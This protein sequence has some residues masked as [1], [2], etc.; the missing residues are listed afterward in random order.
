MILFIDRLINKIV[1]F[2]ILI[3]F[4]LSLYSLYNMLP[5][6]EQIDKSLIVEESKTIIDNKYNNKNIIGFLTIYNTVIN[7]PVMQGKNNT[8]YLYLNYKNEYSSSGSIFLDYRN[9][10]QLKDDFSIIYGHNMSYKAMFS[11]LKYYKNKSYFNTHNKGELIIGK[12][13]YDIN[14]ILYKEVSSTDDI[15][16]NLYLYKN[17][18]NKKIYKYLMNK[19]GNI[20]KI[21]LLSTCKSGYKNKRVI[22]LCE[23]NKI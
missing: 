1:T 3:I 14:I 19:K 17:K 18:R 9:D 4:F 13:K 20:K 15:P 7:Y 22:L 2:L 6:N 11:E 10:K 8:E 16:Y 23:L 21:L 12:D 5:I